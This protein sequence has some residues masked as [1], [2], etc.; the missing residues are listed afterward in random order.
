MLDY[1][2]VSEFW[3]P[4]DHQ[5]QTWG[6]EMWHPWRVTWSGQND[7]RNPESARYHSIVSCSETCNPF[8]YSL[9]S[10][11]TV[12]RTA[13]DRKSLSIRKSESPSFGLYLAQRRW[14]PTSCIASTWKCF[15]RCS[16]QTV[17]FGHFGYTVPHS[18]DYQQR[19][20]SL[21]SRGAFLFSATTRAHESKMMPKLM[22]SSFSSVASFCSNEFPQVTNWP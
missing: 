18:R 1:R 19:R 9:L 6:D 2:S 21:Y 15:S 14:N 20:T 10:S 13:Q 12:A 5:K 7:H 11:E 16:W 17:K 4:E 3:A 22:P 8:I